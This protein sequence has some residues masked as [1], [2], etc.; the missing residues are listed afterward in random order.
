MRS[1][2]YIFAVML[3]ITD[4]SAQQVVKSMVV[5]RDTGEAIPYVNI[6][7]TI[8]MQGTVS[9]AEGAFSISYRSLKD[10]LS[11]SAIGYQRIDIRVEDLLQ[12]P[13]V[14]LSPEV[15]DLGEVQVEAEPYG[16]IKDFGI[17][18]QKRG[19]SVGF[20]S[21]QLGTEIAALIPIEKPT[22]LYSAHYVINHVNKEPLLLR[23]NIYEMKDGVPGSNI[24]PENV[25]IEA[26]EEKGEIIVDLMPYDLM[27]GGDVLLSLEWI[28][29]VQVEGSQGITF[30][31]R[32][33][34]RRPNMWFR[35]GSLSPIQ[36][37]DQIVKMQLGFFLRGQQLSV[38]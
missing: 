8:F 24:L 17:R 2:L 10:T 30:R 7:F 34:R 14:L 3:V 25:L 19:Q 16:P 26:P 22:V 15:Y 29:G 27:V 13:E 38:N 35:N 37:M 20:G 4:L 28:E 18:L 23:L 1:V 5:D 6:G 9:N 32:N 12:L 11:F 31:A 33:V 21:T 36:P